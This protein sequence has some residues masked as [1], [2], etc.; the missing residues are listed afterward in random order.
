MCSVLG[1][2]IVTGILYFFSL[3]FTIGRAPIGCFFA[4][5]ITKLGTNYYFIELA[6]TLLNWVSFFP[7]EQKEV[8]LTNPTS[9]TSTFHK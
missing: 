6:F 9:I 3:M 7:F 2:L 5:V 4:N 8:F 1:V